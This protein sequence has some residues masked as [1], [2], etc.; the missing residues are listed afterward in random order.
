MSDE[1]LKELQALAEPIGYGVAITEFIG[2]Q[3]SWFSVFSID[4]PDDGN[5]FATADEAR[6]YIQGL[7]SAR[8]ARRP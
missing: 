4:R 3:D 7:K 6:A 8:D 5:P 1:P 2:S